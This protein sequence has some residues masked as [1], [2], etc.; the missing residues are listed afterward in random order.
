MWGEILL[1]FA[2]DSKLKLAAETLVLHSGPKFTC[3][4][5]R[6]WFRCQTTIV[7][8]K[9]Y[10]AIWPVLEIT[11]LN[12]FWFTYYWNTEQIEEEN[13]SH[14]GTYLF[15]FQEHIKKSRYVHNKVLHCAQNL[16]VYIST[17]F[18]G[19]CQWD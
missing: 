3:L 1:I 18:K 2:L 16:F 12:S 13:G 8:E 4:V 11:S 9:V 19:E 10:A 7:S 5:V 6:F 17:S 15:E 14:M